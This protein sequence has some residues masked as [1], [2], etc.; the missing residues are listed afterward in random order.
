MAHANPQPRVR[1]AVVGVGPLIGLPHAHRIKQNDQAELVAVCALDPHPAAAE[2]G[3]AAYTDAVELGRSEELHGVVIAAPTHLHAALAKKVIAGA[4]RRGRGVLRALLVEK[5][6][7]HSIESADELI[8]AADAAGVAVLVAHHRRHSRAAKAARRL[9]SSPA[10]GPLRGLM[11][12]WALLKPATYFE[13]DANAYRGERGKGGPL[14]INLIHDV[15]LIRHLTGEEVSAAFA[16]T[17]DKAR[18]ETSV[19]DTG[20][21]SLSLTNGVVC[22]IFFS[23]AAP[24]PWNYEFSAGENAKYPPLPDGSETEGCL[25]LFGAHQALSFPSLRLFS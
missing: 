6:I 5:P 15:D 24:S 23:D 12:T 2:L 9:L 19:E 4:E 8:A 16:T 17:S 13:G 3:V 1:L 14:L 7:A 21:V 22:S 20:A 10:F 18:P 11:G 25:R